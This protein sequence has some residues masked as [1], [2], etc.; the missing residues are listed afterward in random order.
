MV[1]Q[2][3]RHSSFQIIVLTFEFMQH[4]IRVQSWMVSWEMTPTGILEA[5]CGGWLL[6]DITLFR[7]ITMFCGT[8]NIPHNISHIQTYGAA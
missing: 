4:K 1:I 6:L 2:I 5:F 3:L 7:S 8:D